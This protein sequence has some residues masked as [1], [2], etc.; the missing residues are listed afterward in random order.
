MRIAVLADGAVGEK[1]ARWL[2]DTYLQDVCV[3]ICTSANSLMNTALTRGVSV[4]VASDNQQ[5]AEALIQYDDLDLGLLLWWPALIKEDVLS[6]TKLGFVN[7]H[8]SLLPHGRGKHYNFWTIVEQAPF[9]VSL[10]MVEK[11]I[12]SG[13]I[14]AQ[15]EIAYDWCDTGRSLYDKAQSAMYELFIDAYPSLRSGQFSL[16]PQNLGSGSL[17][18][19]KELEPASLIDLDKTYTGR[20][21]L[22]LLRARTFQPH[23]ACRFEDEGVMYQ[24]RVE[25]SKMG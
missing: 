20:D 4:H 19:A 15:K 9:G 16:K 8:P 10:H 1:I 17:H 6:M 11:G 24:V 12:D 2:I 18:Y 25:I 21:L 13:P 7:T 22:N 23:P 3:L 14:V 5:V